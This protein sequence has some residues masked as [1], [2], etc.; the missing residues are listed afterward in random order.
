[1]RIGRSAS[2][3]ARTRVVVV[4]AD[5]AFD[6]SVRTTFGASAQIE[7]DVVKGTLSE[8]DHIDV[9]GASVIVADLD[10]G[11]ELELQALEQLIAR[12]GSWPPVVAVTRSFEGNVAR[13][14]MQMRV[15]DMLVKPVPPVDLVQTCARVAKPPASA[16]AKESQ[17]F[18]F[19]PA[20]GGAGRDHARGAD[21]DAAPQ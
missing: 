10:P 1:M 5:A 11:D 3:G 20:V 4:T 12:I 9:E 13:R 18:T 6:E 8:Q 21:R 19:L 16:D 14:L 17:I 15:A 7:L 2:P